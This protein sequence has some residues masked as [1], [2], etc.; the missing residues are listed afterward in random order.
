MGDLT[1]YS[2]ATNPS[3]GGT[4]VTTGALTAGRYQVTA[5]AAPTGTLTSADA[6][7]I[8][9]QVGASTISTLLMTPTA[10]AVT[11]NPL[12]EVN[13][14]ASTAVLVTAA[15]NSSGTAATYGALMVLHPVALYE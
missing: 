2:H 10:G 9:L 12:V 7:N 6:H 15:G 3:A 1:A 13:V 11:T 4:V 5:F 8:Q 14:P